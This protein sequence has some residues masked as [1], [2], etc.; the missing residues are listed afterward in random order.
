[1]NL[2]KFIQGRPSAIEEREKRHQMVM[3]MVYHF[4][5]DSYLE[6]KTEKTGPLQRLMSRI[7]GGRHS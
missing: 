7:K 6:V 5:G 3:R 4:G 1:M 2:A